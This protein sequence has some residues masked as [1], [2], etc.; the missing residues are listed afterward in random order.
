MYP[1]STD[2]L[3]SPS[4]QPPSRAQTVTNNLALATSSPSAVKDTNIRGAGSMDGVETVRVT[5][6]TSSS[7][8]TKSIGSLFSTIN[9]S[10]SSAFNS[11]MSAPAAPTTVATPTESAGAGPAPA[12]VAAHQHT[13]PD[14]TSV[15][16]QQ[17][18]VGQQQMG[19]DERLYQQA[20]WRTVH[21]QS[22]A[23][24]S[25]YR[26]RTSSSSVGCITTPCSKK[27]KSGRVCFISIPCPNVGQLLSLYIIFYHGVR[28]EFFLTL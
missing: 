25:G 15:G 22:Y 10:V 27:S 23:E 13:E 3:P 9:K 5:D 14:V 24:P 8:F 1:S 28:Y 7:A 6:M 26:G 18:Q 16:Q 19:R 12:T 2:R 21:P 11:L 17:Q 4:V 20:D